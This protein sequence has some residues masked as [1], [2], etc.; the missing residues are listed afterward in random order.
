MQ[1]VD[2]LIQ[3]ISSIKFKYKEHYVLIG[4]L[5]NISSLFLSLVKFFLAQF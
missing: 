4:N 2:I 5:F 3:L 1:S